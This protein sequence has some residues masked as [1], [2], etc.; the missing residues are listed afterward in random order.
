MI[1][2]LLQGAALAAIFLAIWFGLSQIDFLGSV[3]FDRGATEKKLGKLIWKTIKETEDVITNDSVVDPVE[4]IFE[5]LVEKN[6]IN[7]DNIKL[8]IVRSSEINAF[9]LPD[10]HL[11]VYT[12][13]IENCKDQSELAGVIGHEIAH[14][15]K[16]HVMKKLMKE[17]GLAVLVNMTTGGKGAQVGGEVLRA[18]SSSAYDRELE[19]EADR[20]SVNYLVKA[21]LNVEKF[22]EFMYGMSRNQQLPG[23]V[24]WISTHPESE[25]RAVKILKAI[26]G[27]KL[28][29]NDVL[30]KKEWEAL[31]KA[32]KNA[33]ATNEDDIEID[34][35]DEE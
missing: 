6:D 16:D 30:T 12:G 33:K 9:A 3:D 1:K 14:I 18:L 29:V 35:D 23:V 7:D 15:E 32:T 27:K 19:S 21:K 2:T 17:F 22:A 13:L 5:R 4:R 24:Y 28:R 11:V 8:H 20:T 34:F 10:G 25:E 31:Q 26:E